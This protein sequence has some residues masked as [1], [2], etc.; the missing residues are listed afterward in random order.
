MIKLPA[1]VAILLITCTLS[2]FA[3]AQCSIQNSDDGT[4]RFAVAEIIYK[5]YGTEN[6]GNLTQG[7]SLA[8]ANMFLVQHETTSGPK[9]T[10]HIKILTY[11]IGQDPTIVPR[12][13][14]FLFDDGAKLQ[15]DAESYV[16]QDKFEVCYFSLD[17]N[18]MSRLSGPVRSIII[19]DIRQELGYE[20]TKQYGFYPTVLAEQI[21]CLRK[22]IP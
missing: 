21:K 17:D 5:N 20:A 12:R 19:V 2:H 1:L 14:F 13:L 10:W 8:Y 7:G 6:N 16:K 18:A 9:Y 3:A 15:Y 11:H 4:G 22:C